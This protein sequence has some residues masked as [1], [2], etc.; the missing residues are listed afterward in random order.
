MATEA[1]PAFLPITGQ[2]DREA[3]DAT[4][5]FAACLRDASGAAD[6][7]SAVRDCLLL[8]ARAFGGDEAAWAP[9]VAG[10]R[11]LLASPPDQPEE[12]RR[13]RCEL[14]AFVAENADL[15]ER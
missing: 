9:L 5:R 14:R 6:P 8:A 3:L 2:L 13:S 4:L 10:V 1:R 11:D 12:T 15:L 7:Q